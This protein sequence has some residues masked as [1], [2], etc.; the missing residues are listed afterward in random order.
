MN[1]WA[2]YWFLFLLCIFF[3]LD[4]QNVEQTIWTQTLDLQKTSLPFYFPFSFSFTYPL[5]PKIYWFIQY[6]DN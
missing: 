3:L 1:E 6:K 5:H 4:T 2:A